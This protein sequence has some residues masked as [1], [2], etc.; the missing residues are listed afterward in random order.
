MKENRVGHAGFDIEFFT[1]IYVEIIDNI[2]KNFKTQRFVL[3]FDSLLFL[4]I[5]K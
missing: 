5:E 3:D 2:V 1:N 4:L